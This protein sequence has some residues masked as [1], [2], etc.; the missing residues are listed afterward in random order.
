MNDPND[1]TLDKVTSEQ[2]W[3]GVG[4]KMRRLTQAEHTTSAQARAEA[5]RRYDELRPIA[6]RIAST[7][8]FWVGVREKMRRLTQAQ[9]TT[10]TQSAVEHDTT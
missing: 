6:E 7:E 1:Q 8:E 9:D 10:S 5:Q 2:F 3:A 4:E